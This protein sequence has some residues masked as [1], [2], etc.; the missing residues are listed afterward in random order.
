M[1]SIV[2]S[3]AFLF[4]TMLCHG[5]ADYRDF[6][7]AFGIVKNYSPNPYTAEWTDQDWGYVASYLVYE[8]DRRQTADVAG[9][10]GTLAPSVCVTESPLEGQVVE[11]AS[12]DAY[13]LTN[14][15]GGEIKLPWIAKVLYPGQAKKLLLNYKQ[16]EHADSQDYPTPNAYYS[17]RLPAS[18]RYLNIVHS[19]ASAH[20]SK[21][22]TDLLLKTAQE[23]YFSTL[24]DPIEGKKYRNP[25]RNKYARLGSAIC[26]W[27]DVRHFYPY[28]DRHE[29]EWDARLADFI[30]LACDTAVDREAYHTAQRRLLGTI[31]DGHIALWS[32]LKITPARSGYLG[33]FA[34][35]P[36]EFDYVDST[37][38]IKHVKPDVGSQLKQYDIVMRINGTPV[39][40]LLADR[41]EYESAATDYARRYKAARGLAQTFAPDTTFVIDI[42]RPGTGTITDTLYANLSWFYSV[43]NARADRERLTDLGDGIILYDAGVKGKVS[44][45]EI[46]RMNMARA[47]I[48]DLRHGI[49]FD[50]ETTLAHIGENL[51]MPQYP[52]VVSRR[53]FNIG[54]FELP[55]PES[56]EP[57]MPKLTAKAYFLSSHKM[58]SW[59]E[60]VLQIV[61]GNNLGTIVGETSAGTNG[62]A[63]RFYYPIFQLTM[64]GIRAYNVDGSGFFGIGVKPDVEVRPTYDGVVSGRDEVLERTVKMI[65][66]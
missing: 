38:Y 60:T 43:R 40:Q 5:A 42:H 58:I 53:P 13:C 24:A 39:E 45:K 2:M 7:V 41:M 48:Y 37:L 47:V 22:E 46:E 20:F 15:G 23:T 64:T 33:R 35:L 14:Y 6:A 51:K 36:V 57:K 50:F 29:E 59:G 21:K 11:G 49:D 3:L 65:N 32:N 17:Y 10:L 1:K 61:K 44:K 26:M 66:I 62:N 63:T 52:K 18:G 16:L 9:V 30:A 19:I 12:G 54:A 25:L 27:N 34:Y 8:C 56:I 28:I 31:D 55:Q 4:A